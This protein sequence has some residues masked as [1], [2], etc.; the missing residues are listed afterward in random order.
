M[1]Q[2]YIAYNYKLIVKFCKLMQL[3]KYIIVQVLLDTI[4]IGNSFMQVPV[5]TLINSCMYVHTF[6]INIYIFTVA[7]FRLIKVQFSIIA[8]SGISQIR[9]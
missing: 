7:Y 8:F 3:T 9:K 6:P 4:V 1:S 5:L 2:L